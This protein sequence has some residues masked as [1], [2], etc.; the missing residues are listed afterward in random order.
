MRVVVSKILIVLISFHLVGAPIAEAKSKGAQANILMI[1]SAIAAPAVLVQCKKKISS[2]IF[3]GTAGYFLAL[4]LFGSRSHKNDSDKILEQYKG[5]SASAK[6]I[7]ALEAAAESAERAAQ[8]GDKRSKRFKMVALGY[9]AAAAA[10]LVE[11]FLAM[12][13]TAPK[14]TPPCIKPDRETGSC[15][16]G[17]CGGANVGEPPLASSS[18]A[19]LAGG[20]GDGLR[21]N[22]EKTEVSPENAL[23]WRGIKS[24]FS[25]AW[26]WI[27]QTIDSGYTRAAV[28][29]AM[30]AMAFFASSSTK[31][32]ADKLR[33]QAKHYRKLAAKMRRRLGL[34]PGLAEGTLQYIPPVSKKATAET[35]PDPAV[36]FG[37]PCIVGAPGQFPQEDDNC[38]CKKTNTCKKAELPQANYPQ[39]A[40]A[41]SELNEVGSLLKKD[42][43]KVYRGELAGAG[44]L[45][46]A[47]LT[48]AAARVNKLKKRLWG[49]AENHLKK[50]G[51]KMN[52]ALLEQAYGDRLKRVI[53]SDFKN[54]SSPQ[55]S[56]L[57]ALSPA[58]VGGERKSQSE[59]VKKKVGT[60]PSQNKNVIS[61]GG[62]SIRSG[63]K[64][65]GGI[66]FLADADKEEVPESEEALEEVGESD[67]DIQDKAVHKGEERSIWKILSIRYLKSFF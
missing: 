24:L 60:V 41:S 15:T 39:F 2:W 11:A 59:A 62:G 22:K 49:L 13:G 58:F 26:K 3:L 21:E 61:G 31:N 27:K 44:N 32:D 25:K 33:G 65:L 51:Q 40:S 37:G 1:A 20:F 8:S 9:G 35:D 28:F 10:A 67:K 29:G 53:N 66:N 63:Q 34:E 50:E 19:T 55:K 14:K 12:P 30:A 43:D 23:S 45:S 47:K 64:N 56:Q 46:D 16:K 52:G 48:Q 36:A 6:Q 4:E 54:L 57:A 38:A 5:K 7:E 18:G 42:A 17:S